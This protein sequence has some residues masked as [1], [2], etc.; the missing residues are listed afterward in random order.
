MVVE[1]DEEVIARRIMSSVLGVRVVQHDDGSQPAMYDFAFV[2]PDGRLGA[3]EMT[4]TSSPED[5]E[6]DHLTSGRYKLGTGQ[7]SWSIHPRN[8][9]FSVKKMLRHLEVIAEV[10]EAN[11]TT[12]VNVL[13]DSHHQ[14]EPAFKWF[15]EAGIEIRG[16]PATSNPRSVYLWADAIASF[17]HD[18]LTPMLAWLETELATSRFDADFG[19]LAR[20]GRAEQ[21]LVLRVPSSGMPPEHWLALTDDSAVPTRPPAINARHLTGLWLI[22]EMSRSIVYWTTTHGWVREYLDV[23]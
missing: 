3:A 8:N 16:H 11:A 22:P 7:W 17:V 5:R 9:K 13:L 12:D 18:E 14:N 15:A 4:S 6:W 10:A 20:S 2:M 21:H 1:R 23:P 19:K